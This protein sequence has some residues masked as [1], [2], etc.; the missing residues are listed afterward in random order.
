MPFGAETR[1]DGTTRFRLWAPAA[2]TVELWLPDREQAFAMPRDAAGWAE[3][4]TREA[5]PGTAYSFRIDGEL[6]VPDPASRYQPRDVHGPSEVVDPLEYAWSDAEWRGIAPERLVFY[7]LHVGTFSPEG[8]FAGLAERLDHLVAL[9]VTAVE[10]MPV[11]DFPGRWGWGYD[12]VLPFAPDASYGRPDELKAAVEACHARGLAVFLDV[13]YNHFGPEGNHLHRYAPAFLSRD[14]KTPWGAAINFDEPGCEIARSFVVHNALYWVEEFHLDGLRLDAV[15]AMP[16]RS[17]DHIVAELAQAVAEGPGRERLVHLVLENDANEAHLLTRTTVD[18]RP[19][20]LAQWNDDIHHAL[21]V[22]LTGERG[23]YYADYQ[24]PLPHLVRSLTEGFAYQG[25]WSLYRGR[26]RGEPSA[27]LSPTSFVGFLQNHDQVGNRALGERTTELAPP[28][29]VRAATAV[30]FLAPLLPLL[31]M[32]EE[33]A[34]PEPFLFFSDLGPDLAV[35]VSEGR[36]REF[37]RFPEFAS[38]ETIARIPDPQAEGTRAQSVLDWKR[39]AEAP[40]AEWLAFHRQLLEVRAKEIAPLLSGGP[41]PETR[42]AVIGETALEAAWAFP[43]RGVLRL[44]ANLGARAT[45]H[46]GP[47]PAWGRPI[48]AVGARS[49]RWTEL[50]PWSVRWYLS[51]VSR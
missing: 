5:P 43:E 46:E 33:W 7:E 39:L 21:H 37:A 13:V 35:L 49:G 3:W 40:H 14:R 18:K 44:L 23:G 9:G 42:A 50:A 6:L 12:G 47:L 25:Q 34:A 27:T 31:F 26:A 32:G 36:R 29:A 19:L 41:V 24:P 1:D 2:H 8:T 15:H 28:E 10:L 17:H 22:M 48:Y 30:L 45:R 51:E 38:P 4:V 20:F 11:A 16:D